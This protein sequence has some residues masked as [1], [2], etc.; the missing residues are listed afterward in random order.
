MISEIGKPILPTLNPPSSIEVTDRRDTDNPFPETLKFPP[1]IISSASSSSSTMPPPP[2]RLI[3]GST[4]WLSEMNKEVLPY[5]KFHLLSKVISFSPKGPSSPS[6]KKTLARY[7][8]MYLLFR[9]IIPA[10]K[11]EWLRV[12]PW[13][14]LKSLRNDDLVKLTDFSKNTLFF[15]INRLFDVVVHDHIIHESGLIHA[16][17]KSENRG[18]KDK[19]TVFRWW[20]DTIKIYPGLVITSKEKEAGL[21]ERNIKLPFRLQDNEYLHHLA[22]RSLNDLNEEI[23]RF[24][25]SIVTILEESKQE[26]AGAGESAELNTT[27]HEL[28]FN[29]ETQFLK[30]W[31]TEMN[32]IKFQATSLSG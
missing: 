20:S 8:A 7:Y 21:I 17:G 27:F 15:S 13:Y 30:K 4:V 26:K 23:T 18:L 25:Y 3:R 32:E 19:K 16:H 5:P 9:G 2:H 31:E 6:I 10:L 29:V 14:A 11:P 12:H 24:F 28:V 1:L 22:R